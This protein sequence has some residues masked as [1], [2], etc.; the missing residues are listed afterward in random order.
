MVEIRKE[1]NPLERRLRGF[2][3][4]ETF[5]IVL[6]PKLE[7]TL[8]KRNFI[9]KLNGRITDK[10]FLFI[11]RIDY[12]E[13]GEV[14]GDYERMTEYNR[15]VVEYISNKLP[16]N[17]DNFNTTLA[18]HLREL[19]WFGAKDCVNK[20]YFYDDKDRARTIDVILKQLDINKNDEVIYMEMYVR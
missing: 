10:H 4:E 19:H 12:E 3:S 16:K 20:G 9:L 14:K 2:Y 11:P 13:L 6:P 15:D 1:E 17:P 5:N 8:L 7:F 18:L